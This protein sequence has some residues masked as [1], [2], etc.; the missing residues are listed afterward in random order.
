MD[1]FAAGHMDVFTPV[2]KKFTA[3]WAEQSLMTS[4]ERH[5][6]WST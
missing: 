6:A 1:V 2:P 5:C 3:F 4:T